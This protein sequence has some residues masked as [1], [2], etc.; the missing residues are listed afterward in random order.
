MNLNRVIKKSS[1]LEKGDLVMIAGANYYITSH[2]QREGNVTYVEL[3]I[4]ED[5]TSLSMNF[6]IE[7]TLIVYT[8]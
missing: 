1:E 5:V 3:G 6:M 8:K 7:H 4:I 2:P